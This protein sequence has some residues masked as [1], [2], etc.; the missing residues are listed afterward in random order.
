[1]REIRP[2]LCLKLHISS[3]GVNGHYLF[4]SSIIMIY[5][6]IVSVMLNKPIMP[7]SMSTLPSFS[8]YGSRNEKPGLLY[9]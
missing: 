3:Y 7:D 1:M 9:S 6:V 5:H 8:H 4:I 2:M